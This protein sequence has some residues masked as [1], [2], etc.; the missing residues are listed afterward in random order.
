RG[1]GLIRKRG[2]RRAI[3]LRSADPTR[4][5][6][7]LT[8]IV[9]IIS[10]VAARRLIASTHQ[11]RHGAAPRPAASNWRS[12]ASRAPS[13]GI[14]RWPRRRLDSVRSLARHRN[15]GKPTTAPM[16][17]AAVVTANRV[18]T[19]LKAA[20]NHAHA[21]RKCASDDAWRTVRAFREADA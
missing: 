10:D 5:P 8:T 9:P 2:S 20:L 11:P 7:R 15:T 13:R 21:E 4:S 19:I 1:V 18:L 14:R 16:L 3:S 6:T 17:S 12:R